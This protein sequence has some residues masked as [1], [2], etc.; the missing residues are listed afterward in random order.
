MPLLIRKVNSIS[1]PG[2][3]ELLAVPL[4]ADGR[5]VRGRERGVE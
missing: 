4:L 5:G 3:D 2:L 1:T